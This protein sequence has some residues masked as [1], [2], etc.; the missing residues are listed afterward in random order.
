VCGLL[1]ASP[2]IF[3]QIWRFV[4]PGLYSHEK[5]VI[6]PFTVISTVFFLSGAAFGYF[7]VFPP[8]FRF[9]VGYNTEFLAS[10][11]AVGEYFSLAIRLLIAFGVIFE[12]P[13][14][15]VFLA[16]AGLVSVSFLNRHR[17]YAILINFV[18]AAV[19]TPTPDVVNQLMMAGP[20][21]VLYEIS[22]VAVW[23]FGR[24]TFGGF[25]KKQ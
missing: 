16:K 19:L 3:Y 21:L 14:L 23:L 18:I 4:A 7:L 1:L 25:A 13:V 12:M 10:M 5:R 15:M 17:K 2:V 20:L 8:A 24:E 6:L 9:L 22:V 11:P